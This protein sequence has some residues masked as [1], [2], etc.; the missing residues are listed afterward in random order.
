[1]S[2]RERR[3][4]VGFGHS[5]IYGMRI[6]KASHRPASVPRLAKFISIKNSFKRHDSSPRRLQF[7]SPTNWWDELGEPWFGRR[8]KIIFLSAPFKRKSFGMQGV[9]G[10]DELFALRGG[11][12]AFDEGKI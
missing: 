7:L 11:Q 1:M 10:Q 4:A 2:A 5:N 8:T 3:L 6:V 9:V 12:P